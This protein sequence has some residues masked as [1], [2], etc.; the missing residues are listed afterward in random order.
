MSEMSEHRVPMLGASWRR[1]EDP[2]LS[3]DP[4]VRAVVGALATLPAPELSSTFRAELRTQLVA[5][6]PRIIAES[7]PTATS[8]VT[9]IR[10]VSKP[11]AVAARPKHADGA[12]ARLRGVSIGRPLAVAASIITVFAML[13]G[14]AVWMSQK[15]LPGDTLYGL[16]R[17]SES[18]R[19]DLIS[20]DTGKAKYL[21]QLA[22]TRVNEAHGLASRASADALGA[23]PQA[24]VIDSHTAELISSTLGSA[25]SD[26]RNATTL[27]T[28]QAVTSNSSDPLKIITDWAPSQLDR[29]RSLAAAF[30]DG[31]LRQRAQ[32]SAWLVNAAA[33]RAKALV[34]AVVN[35]CASTANAD[36][37]GVR[38]APNCG[39]APSTNTP[40]TRTHKNG[41]PRHP[42]GNSLGTNTGPVVVPVTVGSSPSST[43]GGSDSSSSS[44]PPIDLPTLP[45]H[46]PTLPTTLPVSGSS[47]G[48]GITLGPIGINLG[49]CSS[50]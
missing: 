44:Q 8:P 32:S 19:L 36:S 3:R 9:D 41:K 39:S 46:L 23:G 17:A 7:A 18:V 26:V 13:L 34:P 29:L 12:L 35:G 6:A 45:I 24:G 40:G 43:P 38:P 11:A 28:N 2:A 48:L 5:I 30:P 33:N 20:S 31:S 37:L 1:S 14:G 10:P 42:G 50:P 47:C 21:L 22:E 4:R 49:A 16:K 15:A 27:L 25:D